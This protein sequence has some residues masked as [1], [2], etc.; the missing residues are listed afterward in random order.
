ML[1]KWEI[2]SLGK[3]LF[4]FIK[5][6]VL[7]LLFSNIYIYIYIHIFFS[8][9]SN[10]PLL[11]E[12]YQGR[13][14]VALKFSFTIDDFDKLVNPYRLYECCLGPE[15]FAFVLKKISHEEKS[16]FQSS[17]LSYFLLLYRISSF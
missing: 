15:L 6:A 8:T 7:T 16:R 9:V 2:P 5:L 13:I 10:C 17:I 1:R 3:S 11:K 12:R 14:K 4:L